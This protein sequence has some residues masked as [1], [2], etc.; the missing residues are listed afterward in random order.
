MLNWGNLEADKYSQKFDKLLEK[1]I[2]KIQRFVKKV[3][4]STVKLEIHFDF[5]S[6]KKTYNISLHLVWPQ[7]NH[8]VKEKGYSFEEAVTVG[9]K[10]LRRLVRKDKERRIGI[11]RKKLNFAA[12]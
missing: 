9:V 7:N 8:F 2:A 3:D 10:E 4:E 12:E 1:N 6:H 5:D 11:H